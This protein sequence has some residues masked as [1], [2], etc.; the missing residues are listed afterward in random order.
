[1][2]GNSFGLPCVVMVPFTY[3]TKAG[4]V[5]LREASAAD[6]PALIELYQISFP[7]LENAGELWDEDHLTSHQMRFPEGQI[8][9]TLGD[10]VLGTVSSLI[11][12]LGTDPLR[13]HTFAGITDSDYFYNHDP[14]GDTLYGADVCVHP[15]MRGMGIAK[16]LYEAR[17]RL[18]KKLNLRRILAGGRIVDYC[19]HADAMSAEEYVR[20]VQAG[21]LCDP[22]LSFQLKQ[23]FFV[24]G[25]LEDYLHDPRSC[26]YAAIIEWLNPDYKPE[27]AW[28]SKARVA[29]VQYEVRGID[30][31]AD[32]AQ[33]VQYF[34]ETAADY[35]SEFLLFPELFTAQ[36]LSP[37]KFHTAQDAF[38][39]LATFTDQFVALMSHEAKRYGLY[40]IAGSTVVEEADGRLLNRAF[41]FSPDGTY[42]A[43]PKLHITPSE[44]D[45]CGIDGGS[46]LYL[47]QTP[48]AK[49]GVLICY[50]IEFP[51]VARYLAD[52]G[53]EVIFVP[54]CTDNRQGY[55]RV[56]Y[57]SQARAIENQIYVVT[58]GV[59]GN[60]PG[61]PAMDIHYGRAAVYTPSDFEFARD[62]IQAEADD[63]IETLL[64]TDLDISDLYRSHSEGSVTPQTDRRRDLFEVRAHL[65]VNNIGP[66]IERVVP[67]TPRRLYSRQ[68]GQQG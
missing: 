40:I 12:D 66:E 39:K 41:I 35:E 47:I 6:I 17:R 63:N 42:V 65:D 1:M 3:E 15:D 14:N 27:A 2:R 67:K 21:E 60:L 18:C 26:N 36:L 8:V 33:Q 37:L 50:D 5:Q 56:R 34:T 10:R 61:V 57:C 59:V 19:K 31:F 29:C 9:A 44:R 20:S 13:H 25:V 30:T 4:P 7:F 43:Q 58:A 53:A 46:E 51:E 52:Q 48:K 64:V 16:A 62:G 38:R 23:G 45:W 54:F 11:V 32:F 68:K 22:V 24:R 49:F 55:L 28:G